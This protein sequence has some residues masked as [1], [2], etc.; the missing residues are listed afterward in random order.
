MKSQ[1]LFSRKSKKTI[2]KCP[3]KLLPCMQSVK[4]SVF[5]ANLVDVVSHWLVTCRESS[6]HTYKEANNKQNN[7]TST[8]DK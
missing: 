6:L 2:S 8:N 3:Q 1:S 5:R 7:W 4:L